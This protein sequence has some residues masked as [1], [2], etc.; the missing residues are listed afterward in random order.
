MA[1][2]TASPR[3]R[4]AELAAQLD[5]AVHRR[6]L[7]F[8]NEA[9]RPEDLER[10]K[11]P[12]PAP[13]PHGHENGGDGA[14]AR[15]T[16]RRAI[17]EPQVA[18]EVIEFRDREY[19]LGFR[20]LKELQA[21]EVVRDRHL[22]ILARHFSN[23]FYGSWSVFPQPIP[24]RGP[25]G[26]DGVVHAAL[27]RTGKVLFIT[28]DETT[29]LWNP[30]NTTPATFEDPV[31]Q[32]HLTP[33]ATDGYSVLC[34]GH[35]FLS[36]GRL[37]VAGGGGYGP[38]HKAKW[39]YKFDPVAKTW[40][41]T[42]G[43]MVH[44]RWY[45]TVLTLG[46]G[47]TANSHEVLVVCGHG[48]GDMEIY[49]EAT[50][51]F[52]EVTSGDV[53]PFPNLYPGLHL[54]PDNKVFYSRT[55]WASAGA[56]GGPFVGDD[57]SS[58]FALTGPTTGAW[59]DIAPVTPSMPDRTK[60]MSV[61]LISNTAPH[62]RVLVLGGSDSSNNNT[63]ELIDASALSSATNWGASTPFPDGERR[64]LASAVLLPDGT[65][66]VCGG[67]QQTNSLCALF[68]PEDNSWSPMA[69]LPSIR[70]YHS[71]ALLLPSGQVAMAGWNNTAIEIFSPPYLYQGPRP[72][73]SAAPSSVQRGQ[74]FVVDSPD[75]ATISKIVLVRPMAV[76]HQTDT[77]QKVLEMPHVET[78]FSTF[79][80]I[81]TD[82]TV[83]DRFGVGDDFDAL[84]FV[85]ANVGYGPKHF[86]YLR[87]DAA[88]FS[89]FGTIATNGS[90]TD[91]FGVG[92]D[93][94]ALTFAAP[95]LGYGPDLFYYLRRDGAGSSVFGTISTSGAVTDRFGVGT[96]FDVLTFV[97]EDVGYGPNL[98]YY[99][100]RDAAG[101]STFGTIDPSGAVTDRFGVGSNVDALE[102]VPGN[103]GF[104]PKHFYYLRHD[105]MGFSTFGTIATNG[106]VTDRFGVGNNFDALTF[107][108]GNLGYGPKHF[109]YL[110]RDS[111]Q[112]SVTAPDGGPPHALAPEGYYMMF[113][114]NNNGVPSVA[115]WVRLQ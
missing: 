55:G 14:H 35:S 37:L 6:I 4:P 99:A 9:V 101:M 70:D 29:L 91:R 10:E 50:D 103:L 12:P 89:T 47:R 97:A 106:T 40:S 77:E 26:Y 13:E 34:G 87:H 63:Y 75:A 83:V 102:F 45:P 94:D 86:Y 16:H 61:I 21:L 69:A 64:S 67:I 58:S 90:V 17:L 104:G 51:S 85:A 31:N 88:G 115:K 71:V 78:G 62:V 52:T 109:Y 81:A 28:A 93:F 32:P 23:S 92:D 113:A 44:D 2:K 80:T 43:S 82:G 105:G 79:G 56:G 111:I 108:P 25:G 7:S 65:V 74:S 19:P 27:L 24:R 38:H 49:D 15:E 30:E 11:P 66:F 98:F 100:R 8:L 54:L 112:L 107:A 59:A 73:I 110:R 60:G 114:L 53:K 36:D 39:G 5:A 18:K 72:V 3:T 96:G 46:D 95:D 42:G 68:D 48:A 20:H 1:T 22:D 57:Q 76:T 41:R 33:N 84:V